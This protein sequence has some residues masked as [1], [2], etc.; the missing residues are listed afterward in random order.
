VLVTNV[1]HGTLV[2]NANGT[3]TYTPNTGFFG[4]DSFT[5]KAND[6][7]ADS[8]VVTVTINVTPAAAG[9]IYYTTDHCDP[10][11]TA[12]VING[13][14]G[15][16]IIRITTAT[17]G[18][19]VTVNGV[20][21][22]IFNP[23]GRIIVFGYAGND[24]IQLSGAVPNEAW[25]YGDDGD[26]KLNLGNGGG[27]A[28]G[29]AGNDHINGGSG[30][31]ILVGGEGADRLVGN[32][33]D[34]ILIASRTEYDDRFVYGSHEDAWCHIYDEWNRNDVN[35]QGRVDHLEST[36]VDG[37]NDIYSLNDETIYDDLATDQIDMLTG[38]S[39]LDWYI[40]KAGEDKATGMSSTEADEDLW[41]S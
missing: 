13:T 33:D 25:L 31:D 39:G 10:T 18:V 11:K 22:G 32:A 8:N 7:T 41:I 23:T 29:G 24:D 40:Y 28:F 26:D 9:S 37:E 16:D 17:G 14:S 21:R 30:R 4:T 12:L 38:S 6:G 15:N 36:Q 27:I 19:E 35:F 20:S 5:Y 1:A 34:D 3:F 2:L